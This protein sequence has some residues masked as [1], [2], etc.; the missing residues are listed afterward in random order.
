FSHGAD[1]VLYW[2]VGVDPMLIIKVNHLNAEALEACFAA[3]AHIFGGASYADEA[4]VRRSQDAELGCEHVLIAAVFYGAADQFLVSPHAIDVG[5]VKEGDT[6]VDGAMDR[7][8]SFRLATWSIE[9]AHA[10]A[11]EAN[12]RNL[13]SRS[14]KLACLHPSVSS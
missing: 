3:G 12:G 13:Q 5:R 6:K 9:L 10:H 1:S 4:P 2:R 7:I 8:D 11:A 14:T